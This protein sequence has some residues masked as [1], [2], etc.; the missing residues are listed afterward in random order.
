[1]ETT[2]LSMAAR[3][4]LAALFY[5]VIILHGMV[6]VTRK[7]LMADTK[8][9]NKMHARPGQAL[10]ST[11]EETVLAFCLAVHHLIGGALMLAGQLTDSPALWVSGL[12]IE[13]GFEMVDVVQLFSNA[14]PYSLVQPGLRFITL[15]HHVPGLLVSPGMVLVGGLHMNKDLQAIGWALLLAGGVS[16]LCDGAKQTRD[17]DTEL[18]QWLLL[19]S[20]NMS[21]VLFAR[22]YIFPHASYSLMQTVMANHPTWLAAASIFG[23]VSMSVFNVVVLGIMTGKLVTH[24]SVFAKRQLGLADKVKTN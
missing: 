24:G 13:I 12:C 8:R 14:W 16:L 15:L 22:F 5:G 2:A 19:H 17:L 18:G 10:T 4:C 9:W 1:M 23:I 20:I 6:P 21:G 7:H 11:A 3:V